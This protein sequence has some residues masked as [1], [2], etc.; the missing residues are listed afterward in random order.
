[1]FAAHRQGYETSMGPISRS[2]TLL[3]G[4]YELGELLGRG[5]MG[6]VR[7]GRDRRLGRPVA[8]KVLAEHLASR[9]DARRR[10]EREA[11]A[12]ASLV[13]PNVVTVFDCG[14]D[15][16]VPFL[17]MELLPG[18]TLA[19]ELTH[20]PMPVTRVLALARD[21]LGALACAHDAGIVHRDVKPG[22]V[23]LTADGNAKVADFGIAR[24]LEGADATITTELL[25]TPQ[26]V[27]PERLA[28]RSASPASDLYSVGIILYEAIA[29]RR[30]FDG[31]TPVALLQAVAD[32]DHVALDQLCPGTPRPLSL[33]VERALATDP[34][35][36]FPSARAMAGALDGTT[37]THQRTGRAGRATVAVAA[38]PTEA[39][40]P[41]PGA[42]VPGAPVP[43]APVP[44]ST[45]T[46]TLHSP[47][48]PAVPRTL[49]PRVPRLRARDARE[50]GSVPRRS[51]RLLP[52][53][54]ALT[55]LLSVVAVGLATGNDSPG[56]PPTRG[57]RVSTPTT[58][59][60]VPTTALP[61]IPVVTGPIATVVPA[62]E[63]G[64]GHH[65]ED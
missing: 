32:G 8:V 45:P 61:T 64:N 9:P 50:P 5:G 17:I 4:R 46:R 10:F 52:L 62:R 29:G 2:A 36:R 1:V 16:A 23:L 34:A 20:G 37:P 13:H 40:A 14:E 12:A 31:R 58:V 42:P 54:G 6:E 47:P 3:A 53:L 33:V 44:A 35:V 28:G 63:H 60:P 56:T 19:D 24:T 41:V 21:L 55:A 49:R 25:A 11:R 7:A 43:G 27:A 65:G 15:A 38:T 48:R 26:Y 22:N 51:R 30:P 59:V 18:R 39:I 57:Q